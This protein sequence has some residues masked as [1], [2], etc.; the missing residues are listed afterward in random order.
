MEPLV[1][2]RSFVSAQMKHKKFRSALKSMRSLAPQSSELAYCNQILSHV[3]DQ[4]CIAK[5]H[6]IKHSSLGMTNENDKLEIF[7]YSDNKT[8]TNHHKI[9]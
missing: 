5:F 9:L 7:K 4:N 3:A 1:L 2:I 8:I 6:M